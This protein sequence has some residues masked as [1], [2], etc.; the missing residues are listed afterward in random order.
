MFHS[1]QFQPSDLDKHH[2]LVI[3]ELQKKVIQRCMTRVKGDDQETLVGALSLS[4]SQS[5]NIWTG[6]WNMGECDPPYNLEEWVPNSFDIIAI[7]VQECMS[8]Y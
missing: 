4:N 5:L 6:T 8:R 1:S 7:G 3:K 2:H